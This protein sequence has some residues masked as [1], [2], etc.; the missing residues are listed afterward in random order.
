MALILTV[1]AIFLVLVA[2]EL[3]WRIRRPHDEVSRKAV[4]ILVGCFAASWPWF[5]SRAEIVALAAAF[6]VVVT[7]SKYFNVFQ[8]IHAV[9][10]PTWGELS[11]ALALGVLALTVSDPRIFAVAVLHMG[12]A[13]GVAA[14]VGTRLGAGNA[15][16]VFGHTKSISGSVAFLTVSLL[17]VLAYGL[18]VQ[19][20]LLAAGILLATSLVAT[21][22]ENISV[23]GLDNLTVPVF[24]ALMLQLAA[25]V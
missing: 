11:F 14:L 10:R 4:H 1:I 19:V 2:S 16:K 24:V 5:L 13:D 21:A 7:F 23:R 6:I 20:T 12:L 3:W 18:A 17:L 8:A 9:Q 22:L 15:Y 25:I